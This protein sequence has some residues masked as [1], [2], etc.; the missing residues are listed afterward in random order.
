MSVEARAGGAAPAR[1]SGTFA[2]G[3]ELTVHRLGFGA[4]SAR[5]ASRSRQ[6]RSPVMLPIPG[7]STPEHMRENTDA[8]LIELSDADVAALERPG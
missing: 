5:A 1:A 4:R 8:A 7:T 2:I 3:G 6:R